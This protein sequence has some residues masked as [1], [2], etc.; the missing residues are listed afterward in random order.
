V[1]L[2]T[3]Q[4]S[5]RTVSLLLHLLDLQLSVK[6]GL[7]H[8]RRLRAL[9]S[10]VTFLLRLVVMVMV[11]VDRRPR[12]HLPRSIAVEHLVMVDLLRHHHHRLV[13]EVAR[14][15]RRHLLVWAV[16]LLPRLRH[17]EWVVVL[18]L[19]HLPRVWVGLLDPRRRRE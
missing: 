9:S 12:L 10:V 2:L 1:S 18:R 3:C 15:L 14:R 19:L 17:P 13:W 8:L 5:R 6:V 4:V 11:V 16:D 7:H